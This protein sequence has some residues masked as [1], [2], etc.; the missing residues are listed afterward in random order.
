VPQLIAGTPFEL[1]APVSKR[2]VLEFPYLLLLNYASQQPSDFRA[3][4]RQF[5]V[6]RTLGHGTESKPDVLFLSAF[7]RLD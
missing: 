4:S 5:A 3:E 6:A 1:K 2:K 7:H